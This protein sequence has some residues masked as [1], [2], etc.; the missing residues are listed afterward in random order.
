MEFFERIAK[1]VQLNRVVEKT[2]IFHLIRFLIDIQACSI[3]LLEMV[4]FSWALLLG[5]FLL[6]VYLGFNWFFVALLVFMISSYVAF[7]RSE[8]KRK[9]SSRILFYLF[10]GG[11]AFQLFSLI[12]LN[13]LFVAGFVW[14]LL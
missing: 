4:P 1:S 13:F 8:L 6:S 7:N 14:M 3:V 5:L 10:F 9:A 12:F 11:S 2:P